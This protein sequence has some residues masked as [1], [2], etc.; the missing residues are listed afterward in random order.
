M[1]AG[2]RR[3]TQ[4]KAGTPGFQ[5][6]EQLTGGD[7]GPHCDV[8]AFGCVALE[9][10]SEKPIWEGL[11]SHAI[12]FRVGVKGEFPPAECS[13]PEVNE[14][15]TCCFKEI[16]ARV[17]AVELLSIICDIILSL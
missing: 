6:P 8:Y 10:F 12:M 5:S 1:K 13:Q 2:T 11:S 3:T 9:L 7:I 17:A 4:F 15:I 14:A 16:S